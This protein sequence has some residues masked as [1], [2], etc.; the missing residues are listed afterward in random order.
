[1]RNAR[2]TALG[3]N[4]QKGMYNLNSLLSSGDFGSDGYTITS[5]TRAG[6]D[7]SMHSSGNAVDFGVQDRDGKAL[8]KF[9]FDD[10]D[11]GSKT[12]SSKGKQY[13]KDNNAELIDE[14]GNRKGAHFHLEFNDASDTPYD[15]YPSGYLT[16]EGY[17]IYG[18]EV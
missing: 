7:E 13:L 6:G 2:D 11:K 1:V 9:F 17:P 4:A 10:W 5:A 18:V 15:M 3:G 8:N 16:S 12:L 14:R